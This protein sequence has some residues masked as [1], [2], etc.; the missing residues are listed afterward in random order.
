MCRMREG[1][2]PKS[3][4]CTYSNFSWSRTHRI[5]FLLSLGYDSRIKS[6]Q[7]FCKIIKI[8]VMILLTH[9]RQHHRRPAVKI[10]QFQIYCKILQNLAPGGWS[11]EGR[12]GCR[13]WRGLTRSTC[14]NHLPWGLSWR[15]LS[16]SKI[17][18]ACCAQFWCHRPPTQLVW[19]VIPSSFQG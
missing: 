19:T 13:R 16:I 5:I 18:R 7:I 12:C 10:N 3:P 14:R 11:W 8:I 15:Y 1:G 9:S 6:R 4:S 2:A 17:V